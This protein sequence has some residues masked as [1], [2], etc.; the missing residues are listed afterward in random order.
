MKSYR[1][2]LRQFPLILILYVQ[3][4]LVLLLVMFPVS[5]WLAR[6]ADGNYF[7]Y[8]L[9]IDFV[10]ESIAGK[11]GAPA[12][13]TLLFLVLVLLFLI[14]IFLM[15]GIFESLLNHY[16]GFR[17]FLFDCTAHARRFVLLFLFYGIPLLILMLIISG[18][19][20]GFA[21]DSPNQMMPVT[22][23]LTGRVV[24]FFIAAIVGYWHTAA[25]F[26]TV[27]EGRLRLAFRIKFRLFARYLG[28]QILAF[29]FGILIAFL[30]YGWLF[31]ST[32]LP[33]TGALI[34]IQLAIL[35]RISFKLASY[36]VLS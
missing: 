22:M 23:F 2:V 11:G 28:Y 33:V 13:L 25:R 18:V 19:L 14:R 6:A 24:V 17:R 29:I 31:S 1:H 20:S 4:L 3:E 12:F 30:G 16:P 32:V 35:I 9:T 7:D 26:R 10:V 15:A 21:D 27:I 34:L 36:K 8:R 5:R